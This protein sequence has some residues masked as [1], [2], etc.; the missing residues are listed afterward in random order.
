M[1]SVRETSENPHD[2]LKL[3]RWELPQWSLLLRAG[4]QGWIMQDLHQTQSTKAF[5]DTESGAGDDPGRR[6]RS[7]NKH[8]PLSQTPS[9]HATENP[10]RTVSWR[11]LPQFPTG[12]ALSDL[13]PSTLQADQGLVLHSDHVIDILEIS[14]AM[15]GFGA[16]GGQ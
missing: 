15:G 9:Q 11:S 1:F 16:A 6:N 14:L 4:L 10:V 2:T 8:W 13:T 3:L 12:S 7:T 5:K